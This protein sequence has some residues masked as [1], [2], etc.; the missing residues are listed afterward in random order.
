MGNL[1]SKAERLHELVSSNK[2]EELK[3]LLAQWGV[4][5]NCRETRDRRTPL[6]LAAENGFVQCVELLLDKGA[7]VNVT[8][9]YGYTPLIYAAKKGSRE[10]VKLLLDKGADVNVGDNHWYTPLIYAAK[11]GSHEC[12]KLF[13]DKGADVNARK[14]CGGDT[15]LAYAAGKGSHECVKLLLDKGADVNVSGRHGD[16]PLIYALDNDSHECVELLL[17]KGA[18][19]NVTNMY[20]DTP[21]I[22]AAKKGCHECVKLL[23]DKGADVNVGNNIGDTPLIYAVKKGSNECLKALLVAGANANAGDRQGKTP[24]IWAVSHDLQESVNTLVAA[25]ADVNWKDKTGNSVLFYALSG[26]HR[27]DLKMTGFRLP[28][29]LYLALNIVQGGIVA[30][31]IEA[32]AD[33]NDGFEGRYNPLTELARERVWLAEYRKIMSPM[34]CIKL[35]LKVGVHVNKRSRGHTALTWYYYQN[36]QHDGIFIKLLYAAGQVVEWPGVDYCAVRR[37]LIPKWLQDAEAVRNRKKCASLR[38]LCRVSI[39]SRFL[40]LD[41]YTNLFIRV[42][43]LGLPPLLTR[44]LLFDMTLDTEEDTDNDNNS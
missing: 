44:Y 1:V 36:S 19:V 6:M 42:P 24:L 11:K 5:V 26:S 17:D 31:L 22:Y 3:E 39:R 7:D 40:T 12:V 32:G 8:N 28:Y 43:K 18:D 29:A 30:L 25:G 15:P 38:D 37:V 35:L 13:L 41:R 9:I 14:C 20:G 33:V 16:T 10:C 23:L 2:T 34:K 4:N 27:N 21:L